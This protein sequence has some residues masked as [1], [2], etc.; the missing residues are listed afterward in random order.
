MIQ[1]K[2]KN[3]RK[4]KILETTVHNKILAI[5]DK[6][7]DLDQS[8]IQITLEM[9][10][11]PVQAGPDY[12]K[13][14]AYISGGRYEGIVIEKSDS[15]IYVSVADLADHMLEVLNRF[16]DKVRVKQRKQAREFFQQS[17]VVKDDQQLEEID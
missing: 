1:I 6:F 7:P 2:F 8:K 16:G 4:S 10:N 9:Q 5:I 11:S 14:K 13:V 12:F 17:N 15:N 3:L